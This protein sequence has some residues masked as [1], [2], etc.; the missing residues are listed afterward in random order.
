MARTSLKA[1]PS[2]DGP[3]RHE[4]SAA[5]A[6]AGK[7]AHALA[8]A[9][10]DDVAATTLAALAY[11]ADTVARLALEREWSAADVQQIVSKVSALTDVPGGNRSARRLPAGDPR[12][13]AARPS[14][15]ARHR[16]RRAHAH[17]VRSGA[18]SR[19]CGRPIRTSR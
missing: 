9:A 19:A 8:A 18:R 6:A 15:L 2:N 16:D 17:R 7:R 1:R 14:A 4:T 12:P 3:S 13:T 5:L 11:A 10:G